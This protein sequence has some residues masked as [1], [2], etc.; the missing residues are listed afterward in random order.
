MASVSSPFTA[1]A[2]TRVSSFRRIARH[3]FSANH[4][5]ARLAKSDTSFGGVPRLTAYIGAF[6]DFTWY[7]A[8][9]RGESRYRLCSCCL[10]SV[11]ITYRFV[12]K[13]TISMATFTSISEGEKPSISVH[14]TNKIAKIN[15]NIYG[16]FT[17]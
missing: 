3:P 1:R 9:I 12:E 4:T 16:G 13:F 6:S 7:H 15:E 5:E 17:E 10:Y 2:Y 14:P 11:Q 8:T